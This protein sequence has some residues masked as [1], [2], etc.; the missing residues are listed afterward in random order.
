MKR[1]SSAWL[2]GIRVDWDGVFWRLDAVGDA[3]V[4]DDEAGAVLTD[5]EAVFP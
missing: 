5:N 3:A 2:F 1:T 4:P